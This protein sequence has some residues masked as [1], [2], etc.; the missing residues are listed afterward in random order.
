MPREQDEEPGH[1]RLRVKSRQAV[2][3]R[4]R[5][6][7]QYMQEQRDLDPENN[8]NWKFLQKLAKDIDF[9]R[10]WP[11][12]GRRVEGLGERYRQRV[13]GDTYWLY[14]YIAEGGTNEETYLVF[15]EFRHTS[16]KPIKS[17]TVRKYKNKADRQS[18]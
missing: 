15:I 1:P 2:A 9:I 10:S 13:V 6:I 18:D 8:I 12:S 5:D 11:W 3:E 4:M 17:G 16:Q 7:Y 14:Y